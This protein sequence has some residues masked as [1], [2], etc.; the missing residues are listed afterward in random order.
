[1]RAQQVSVQTLASQRQTAGNFNPV[2]QTDR[3]RSTCERH[4]KVEPTLAQT[5]LKS[6]P[7]LGLSRR[8]GS[9]R[10]QRRVSLQADHT[11]GSVKRGT[12]LSRRFLSGFCARFADEPS[13]R[14]SQFEP[15]FFGRGS[16]ISPTRWL[17]WLK[18]RP[19][20][21]MVLGSVSRQG[22]HLV[23]GFDSQLECNRS[24]FLFHTDVS[25]S[26]SLSLSLPPFFSLS[27]HQYTYSQVRI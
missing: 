6:A 14:L 25:L 24:L 11:L 12:S 2:R 4:F 9:G 21:Q 27:E 7:V 13:A 22:T 8:G 23:C 20:H 15:S 10:N 16:G 26:L 18:H 19:V 5:A 1:M 17:H 3:A